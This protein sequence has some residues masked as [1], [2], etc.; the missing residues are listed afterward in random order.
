MLN[1]IIVDDKNRVR[2]Y[3]FIREAAL[4]CKCGDSS[5]TLAEGC[6]DADC[7]IDDAGIMYALCACGDGSIVCCTNSGNGWHRYTVM[8]SKNGNGDIC[9]IRCVCISGRLNIWYSLDYNG[10]KMLI[11]QLVD[12]EEMI[13]EPYVAGSLGYK[14]KFDICCDNDKNTYVYYVDDE[15]KLC[16]IGYLW[17]QKKYT[18]KEI[19][20][21]RISNVAVIADISGRVCIAAIGKKAEFNVVYFK[22]RGEEDFRILGFGV[23]YGCTPAVFAVGDSIYV[24]WLDNKECCE[25]VSRDGGNSFDRPVAIGGMRGGANDIAAYKNS[26]NPLCL[27]VN[28]CI[29]N[30]AMKMLHEGAI[31]GSIKKA[32]SMSDELDEYSKNAAKTMQVSLD[33]V[34]RLIALENQISAI[35]TILQQ[36]TQPV[37][38]TGLEQQNINGGI[39][40]E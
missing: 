29:C 34:S 2:H 31:V 16:S 40:D 37:T 25:C 10:K 19:V 9:G 27:G 15:E 39:E 24:Q 23:D 6:T 8:T 30:Y 14:K 4:V 12:G 1:K 5:I 22:M 11:H 38:T 17:S 28:R 21:D 7:C 13:G 35:A 18:P 36:L 33:V 32:V 20:A 26:A 3:F